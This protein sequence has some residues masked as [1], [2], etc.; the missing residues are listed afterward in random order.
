[1]GGG[2][3]D[4][5]VKDGLWMLFCDLVTMRGVGGL[6]GGSFWEGWLVVVD[7]AMVVLVGMR[8]A[9]CWVVERRA[10]MF[11]GCWFVEAV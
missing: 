5:I 7:S 3:D 2:N 10:G 6:C 9:W 11:C 8:H 1:M 4:Y